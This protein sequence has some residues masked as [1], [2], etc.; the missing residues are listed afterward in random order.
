MSD[1]EIY[2]ESLAKAKD[3]LDKKKKSSTG[4]KISESRL[5]TIVNNYA[6]C[7]QC[8]IQLRGANHNTEHIHPRAL[9]GGNEDANKIQ[10]CISCNNSRNMVMQA[11]LGHPPFHKSYPE[12]WRHVESYILWSERTIDR[13]LESGAIYQEIHN[14]FMN[15]RF[16]G[17]PLERTIERFYGRVSTWEKGALPQSKNLQR[18]PRISVA[19]QM[20]PHKKTGLVTKFF[21]KVFGYSSSKPSKISDKNKNNT[22]EY[23]TRK[24]ESPTSSQITENRTHSKEQFAEFMLSIL[25]TTPQSLTSIG[26]KIE[27]HLNNLKM[28]KTSTSFFLSMHGLPRGLKK[29]IENQLGERVEITG[30]EPKYFVALAEP[31]TA[32]LEQRLENTTVL[33]KSENA[34]VLI[35]HEND[36]VPVDPI[37]PAFKGHV[38]ASLKGMEGEIKLSTLS[39][40][41]N[42]YLKSIGEEPMSFRNFGKKYGIPKNSNT[43]LDILTKYFSDVVGFRKEG[44]VVYIWII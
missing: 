29:A 4:S 18:Q 30:A 27:A 23:L 37:D 34:G 2:S 7:P 20:Q 14:L 17:L 40:R 42:R 3:F 26:K 10:I 22:A 15:Y 43:G 28:E 31:L 13:G 32:A 38:M 16:G 33:E 36:K 41:L 12:N 21:D 25:T 5:F 24:I 8:G 6:Q 19:K 35:E 39:P 9:G 11:I 44:T 1:E